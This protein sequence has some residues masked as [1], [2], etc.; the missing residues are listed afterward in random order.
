MGIYR[1]IT[2][3]M[4]NHLEKKIDMKWKLLFLRVITRRFEVDV[5]WA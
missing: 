1:G 5:C 4:E 3:I 2:P